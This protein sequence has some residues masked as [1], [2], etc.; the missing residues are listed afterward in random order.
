MSQSLK[1]ISLRTFRKYLEWKGLKLQRTTGGHELW[2]GKPVKRPICLQ[3]HIDP[4]PEFII[5]QALRTLSADRDDFL[6]F[7]KNG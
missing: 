3:T 4:I 7:L 5:K 1:N 6:D 2:A